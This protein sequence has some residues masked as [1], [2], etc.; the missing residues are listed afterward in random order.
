[1]A[2]LI[3]KGVTNM[4]SRN[5]IL[6]NYGNLIRGVWQDEK[7]LP[8]LQAEPKQVLSSFGFDVPAEAKVNLIVRELNEDDG[9]ST[10][11]E[12]WRT[13]EETGVYDFLIHVR[14]ADVEM[15]E[16]PLHED[17]LEMMAGGVAG[18]CCCCPCC[19]E[20]PGVA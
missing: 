3:E 12:L 10:Q 2:Y 11:V 20:D 9:P 19:C 17:V 8:R 15:D 4:L 13:G 16:I 6:K 5:D 14:P 7:V 18:A 1:M